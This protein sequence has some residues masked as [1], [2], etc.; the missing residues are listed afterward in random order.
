MK[1]TGFIKVLYKY[2]SQLHSGVADIRKK[3]NLTIKKE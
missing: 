1:D 3:N 2:F